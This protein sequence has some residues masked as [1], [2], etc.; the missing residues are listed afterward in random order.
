MHS[1]FLGFLFQFGAVKTLEKL[2]KADHVYE[3]MGDNIEG[4]G[5]KLDDGIPLDRS[6]D[7]VVL[8]ADLE[9]I[10]GFAP[11]QTFVRV[12]QVSV[13]LGKSSIGD[14]VFV[15]IAQRLDVI[16]IPLPLR[17]R[18]L[19]VLTEKFFREVD[20]LP[21]NGN[22]MQFKRDSF[23]RFCHPGH[24]EYLPNQSITFCTRIG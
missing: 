21:Q 7:H 4:K 13:D 20:G 14:L 16:A 24:L 23:Y 19:V 11:A 8:K 22:F 5:E 6:S 12:P 17:G 1:N 3:F 2:G 10:A 15:E 9:K 18:D